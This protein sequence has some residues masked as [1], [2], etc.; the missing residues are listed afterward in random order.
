MYLQKAATY[1]TTIGREH[2]RVLF[3]RCHENIPDP[4]RYLSKWFMDAPTSE[5]K[6]EN[7]KDFFRW[8]FL[9][10]GVPNT[11]DDEELEEYIRETEKLLG[12]KI[13]PRR[14]NVN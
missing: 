8:A 3:Q 13:E 1:P 12:R 4:E 9:N 5:I 2:R 14:G 7:V 10:T 6:R 11:V